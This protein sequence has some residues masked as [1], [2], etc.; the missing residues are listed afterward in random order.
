M[1]VRTSFFII[2]ALAA[3]ILFS[4]AASASFKISYSCPTVHC[5]EGGSIVWNVS[6]Q[7]TDKDVIRISGIELKDRDGVVIASYSGNLEIAF[8]ESRDAIFS[9]T[10]PPADNYTYAYYYPCFTFFNV[11]GSSVVSTDKR[12]YDIM[13]ITVMPTPLVRC[14]SDLNCSDD[15]R[16]E[17]GLCFRIKCSGC[18][19]PANH[20]CMPYQC[21]INSNCSSSEGCFSHEC[22]PLLCSGDYFADEHICK[23]LSCGFLEMGRNNRCEKNVV[24]YLALVITLSIS[25]GLTAILFMTNVKIGKKTILKMLRDKRT[26]EIHK[27]QEQRQLNEAETHRELLKYEKDSDEIELHKKE[28]RR[29]E[30]EARKERRT[31]EQLM[32]VQTCPECH[33]LIDAN[34]RVCPKCGEKLRKGEKKE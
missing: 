28:I 21:C 24:L 30:A 6:I 29:H 1:R 33:S 16:C 14:S 13:N 2:I 12:C 34:L 8:K 17:Q 3:V 5:V 27:R 18:Q 22:K 20:S 10:A 4:G 26:A 31:W 32:E 7:N 9:S 11:Q 19:F 23:K 25:L 15:S